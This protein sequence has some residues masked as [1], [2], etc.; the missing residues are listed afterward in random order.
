MALG[1]RWDIWELCLKQQQQSQHLHISPTQKL[2]DN[3]WFLV[4]MFCLWST[5][6]ADAAR[7]SLLFMT[8]PFCEYLTR[9]ACLCRFL[10]AL[11]S[12]GI[13][14]T[15]GRQENTHNYHVNAGA[16]VCRG[17]L[18]QRCASEETG[19]PEV[20]WAALSTP[21]RGGRGGGLLDPISRQNRLWW[22]HGKKVQI[23]GSLWHLLFSFKPQ[24]NV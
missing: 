16:G 15:K 3:F 24:T 22:I 18:T 14:D 11:Y 17:Q 10:C 21:G 20:D 12:P 4:L 1:R 9:D 8:T 6:D 5:D 7:C 13:R 23:E 2:V 19:S